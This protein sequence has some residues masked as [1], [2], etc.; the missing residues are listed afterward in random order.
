MFPRYN[1]AAQTFA[2]IHHLFGT[3]GSDAHAP[4]EIGRALMSLPDFQNSAQLKKSITR[5]K[6]KKRLSSPF[7]H[8]YSRYAVWRKSKKQIEFPPHFPE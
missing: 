2:K 8:F 7:V 3:A 1:H 5:A 4:F 6:Y